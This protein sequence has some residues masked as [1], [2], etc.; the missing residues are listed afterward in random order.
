MKKTALRS[1][2]IALS[3][4]MLFS[5][6]SCNTENTPD[7]PETDESKP[8]V[9]DTGSSETT[10]TEETET[11]ET[12]TEEKL[13]DPQFPELSKSIITGDGS[14]VT[15]GSEK[16]EQDFLA[17]VSYFLSNG[18][19]KYSYDTIG[20]SR[21][22][23][24]VKDDEYYTLVYNKELCELTM[25]HSASGAEKLPKQWNGSETYEKLC[26][27]SITQH[28]SKE[29]NGMGYIFRLEDGS[30]IVYD[31]GYKQ[32]AR[33]LIMSLHRLALTD[34]V[35]VRA[36]IITHDHD[37]HYS[38]FNEI[39]KSFAKRLKIDY[40]MYAPTTMEESGKIS[41]YAEQLHKDVAE[42]EGAV[43]LPIHAGMTFNILNV[44][45]EILQT[46]S[47]ISIHGKITDFNDTSIISRVVSDEGSAIMLADACGRTADWLVKNIG[48]GLKSDI[49]QV[50]HHGVETGSIP[51]Y[52]AIAAP[53]LF[54][55][56][57]H[58]LFSSYRGEKIK[59]HIIEAEY[60]IEH[61]LH[62][63]GTVTRKLSYRPEKPDYLSAMPTV[64]T[65]LQTSGDAS[66]VRIE[67][68]ILKYDVINPT[69]PYVVISLKKVE[70]GINNAIRIVV[71]AEDAKDGHIYIQTRNDS[72]FSA[73]K[74]VLI[75]NQGTST[76][77]KTTYLVY[78]G[79]LPDF[80]DGLKSLRIDFGSEEGQTVEI[81][82][83]EFFH[84]DLSEK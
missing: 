54:W 33:D 42:F 31:G 16:S 75:G 21:R 5:L 27:T 55:S 13:P 68:G 67:D 82:S 80:E 63:Y 6:F 52:D 62:S 25:I 76:D 17:A 28:Y 59:Q 37:D 77:G 3:L 20:I 58:V 9:N 48:S 18:F 56:C 83:I 79:N 11:E 60:S 35:H 36:W 43:L 74:S 23:T 72:S 34:D 61:V 69:D 53:M 7:S 45:L 71:D 73:E 57:D 81:Y 26:D 32:D 47:M 40:V 1:L 65:G 49:V 15:F 29:I 39:A 78:V 51:L 84:L 22:G 12:E 46:P 19:T 8:A 41:Y 64:T 50:A 4:I 70:T 14:T 10:T 66:N 44:K 38:A 24:F 2:L 30:F